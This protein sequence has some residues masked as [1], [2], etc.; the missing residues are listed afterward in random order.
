M[1]HSYLPEFE[2]ELATQK[3]LSVEGFASKLGYFFQHHWN[4]S[5]TPAEAEPMKFLVGGFDAGDA[6]GRVFELAIPTS[7]T[8][9]NQNVTGF[10]I[11]FGGQYGIA[12]RLLSG[13]GLRLQA[14]V[15]TDVHLNAAQTTN[16]KRKVLEGLAM[17][18]PY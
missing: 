3:R 14:L 15:K 1:A 12:A 9:V 18:I 8:P 5:N 6:Y 10:G 2:T 4:A 16:F 7:P 11:T 13:Y 17:P